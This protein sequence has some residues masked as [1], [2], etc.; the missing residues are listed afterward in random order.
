MRWC[1][2]PVM[3]I[4]SL[5][6][7][8]SLTLICRYYGTISLQALPMPL[9]NADERQPRIQSPVQ[10]KCHMMR[11]ESCGF[12]LVPILPREWAQGVRWREAVRF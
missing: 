3:L 12:A 2:P 5:G 8:H 6:G 1:A 7:V 9:S 11:D 10:R 4:G